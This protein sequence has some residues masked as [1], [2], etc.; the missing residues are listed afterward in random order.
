MLYMSKV[1]RTGSSIARLVAIVA[2][3]LL[4]PL[5]VSAAN[6]AHAWDHS[7]HGTVGDYRAGLVSGTVE[8]H[9]SPAEVPLH[10]HLM[11]HPAQ[12]SGLIP[13]PVESD[14]PLLALNP[15]SA[16]AREAD[17]RLPVVSTQAPIAA[18]PRF[19]LF[20]NFRS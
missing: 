10:C 12:A 3:L 9:G 8:H 20:G 4:T 15:V 2:V 14:P 16:P 6:P 11:S 18:S 13:K 1:R 7:V 19:I 5:T 17:T